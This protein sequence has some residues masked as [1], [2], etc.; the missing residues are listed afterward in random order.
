[1]PLTFAL[2]FEQLESY[3]DENPCPRDFE[4]FRGKGP[5]EMRATDP[6]IQLI[7]AEFEAADA[8]CFHLYF[9]G[10]GATGGGRGGALTAAHP[11][12]RLPQNRL[13]QNNDNRP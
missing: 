5:A 9:T 12:C 2:P 8:E 7:A 10:V 11:I 6:Q 4:A 1:M 3:R 13:L